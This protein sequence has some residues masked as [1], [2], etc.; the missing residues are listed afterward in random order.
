MRA[1][2]TLGDLTGNYE[3]SVDVPITILGDYDA[4][5]NLLLQLTRA[6]APAN[7]ITTR[8][9]KRMGNEN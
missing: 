8:Q 2:G 5:R 3:F 9:Q 1:A 7:A 4:L 6:S